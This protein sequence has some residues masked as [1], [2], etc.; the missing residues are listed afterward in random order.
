MS[1]DRPTEARPGPRPAPERGPGAAGERPSR[2]AEGRDEAL[3]TFVE[4]FAA[5]LVD[6]GMQRMGS[7]VFACLL[8]APEGALS[9]AELSERLQVSPAAVSGAVRYL[10]QVHLVT[11]ERQPGSRRERYRLHHDTWYQAMVNRD[12]LINRWLGSLRTG[13]DAVGPA[14]P[15]GQRLAETVDFLTFFQAE[16]HASLERWHDLRRRNPPVAEPA[17]G[18]TDETAPERGA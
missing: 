7:R 9:S 10:S 12:A 11:R 14:T 5:D 6:A 13:I 17:A 3:S 16:L 4:R 8:T 1:K 18:G 2:P 15:A